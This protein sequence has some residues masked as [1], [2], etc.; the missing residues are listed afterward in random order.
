MKHMPNELLHESSP[1]LKQHAFNP[2]NWRAW[3]QRTLAKAVEENKLMII[4]IGYSTCHWCHVMEH[5]SFENEEVAALMNEHFISVK[6]DR[7]ERPDVDSVYMQA[8]QLM[9]GK[10]G[11]PLNCITLPDGKPLYGGTFFPRR[12]WIHVLKQVSDL[13][14]YEP[15]R[16]KTYA[17]ELIAGLRKTE[18]IG[19]PVAENNPLQTIHAMVQA[20]ENS[21]DRVYGGFSR[22]PKFPMPGNWQFLMRYAFQTENA[23]I[24]NQLM[25]TLDRM[26]AG[27][28]YDHVAGGFARY[29]T[30]AEW[31]IPHFEKMLYDNAQLI[32]LYASAYAFTGKRNYREIVTETMHFVMSELM[33]PDGGFYSALDADTEG[34][35]GKFYVWKKEEIEFLLKKD[36]TLFSK[37]FKVNEKGYWENGNYILLRNEEITDIANES[38]LAEEELEVKIREWK[39]ILYRHRKQRANPGLDNKFIT[40]WNALMLTACCD[41]YRYTGRQEYLTLA[42]R[43]YDFIRKN[44]VDGKG[45]LLHAT[46]PDIISGI[47]RKQ[48]VYAFADD[49]A[50]LGLAYFH[51]FTV[52]G[53]ERFISHAME[54]LRQADSL[55]TDPDTG[56]L[57]YASDMNDRLIIRRTETEDNVIPSANSMFAHLLFV[58]GRITGNVEWEERAYRLCAFVESY[59]ASYPSAFSNWGLLLLNKAYPFF[60]LAITGKEAVANLNSLL[61]IYKPDIL[62]CASEKESAISLFRNRYHKYDTL[63]YLCHDRTCHQPARTVEELLIQ[64]KSVRSN[65]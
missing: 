26:A 21:F 45:R 29:S 47:I 57:F 41:A 46:H 34:E 42:L 51:L 22:V 60:E 23:G 12:Q 3:N 16:C 31:K 64:I 2:V 20:F 40:S 39:S 48:P 38:G 10:G 27:G 6:V 52:T 49:Y 59:M 14:K 53:E 44:L 5:D 36:A 8:V 50:A 56:L 33:S 4:S 11:W 54:C 43:N 25:L 58:L 17:D 19:K 15:E 30:D 62:L 32:S 1:Y 55:F 9:T 24:K 63:F 28:I 61:S 65:S 7:E 13:W 18:L 37:V 35:E